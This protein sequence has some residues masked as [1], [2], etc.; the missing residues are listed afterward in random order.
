MF[1]TLDDAQIF[2]TAFGSKTAPPLLALGGWIGSWEDWLEPLSILSESRRVLAYD[3]RG[4]GVTIAPVETI[5]FDRLVDD[6]FAVMDAFDVER[7]VLA[8]MSMGAAVAL[9]AALRRPERISALVLVDSLD[10][11]GLPPAGE[12]RFLLGLTHDYPRALEGFIQACVPEADSEPIK[13]W[14][15]HILNRASQEAALTLYK[16][17]GTVPVRENLRSITQPTLLIHGD[18]DYIAPLESA[19]WLVE[20]LPQ[21]ILKVIAGAG[22]VPIM[23][24]PDE[25]AQAIQ[26]FCSDQGL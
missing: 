7:S 18:A 4:S 2:A 9:G 21:A 3:H 19:H 14:G 6:V 17:A 24:R 16:M 15:R 8:A 22:H 25:V 5:T 13:H 26:R 10:L 11:R 1:I 12:D 20:T 23:T